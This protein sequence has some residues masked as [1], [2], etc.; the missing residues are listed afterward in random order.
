MSVPWFWSQY[1]SSNLVNYYSSLLEKEY[2]RYQL[3][4]QVFN[5]MISNLYT[6]QMISNLC[7]V[8]KWFQ[9]YTLLPNDFKL[10][11]CYQMI[12]NLYTFFLSCHR[13]FHMNLTSFKRTPVLNDHFIF[14]PKVTSL[15][16]FECTFQFATKWFKNFTVVMNIL[17]IIKSKPMIDSV[18]FLIHYLWVNSWYENC[19]FELE[20]V[21]KLICICKYCSF[22]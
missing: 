17:K 15:C 22:T 16:R 13:K 3:L 2:L 21:P 1:T 8:T 12:S 19:H 18:L 7:T 14:F 10:I 5:Q 9:I 6:F 20:F 4:I 11:H